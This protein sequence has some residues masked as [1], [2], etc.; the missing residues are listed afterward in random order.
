MKSAE[1]LAGL[2][3]AAAF[4]AGTA[5][6]A[7]PKPSW[8]TGEA[9][10]ASDLNGNFQNLENR[11]ATL[12]AHP[13]REFVFLKD[14]RSTGT[15]GGQAAGSTWVQRSLNTLEN[16]SAYSWVTLNG[17]QFTL[18]PGTYEILAFVPSHWVNRAQA[19]LRNLTDATTTLL[20]SSGLLSEREGVD[21]QA[22]IT[23]AN[24]L[25]GAFKVTGA[26]KTFQIE[27]IVQIPSAEDW[28]LGHASAFGVQ[29]VYTQVRL[30]RTGP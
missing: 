8:Q 14:V 25:M 6:S 10:T 26:T 16:P 28:T 27:S 2:L 24:T 22:S 21:G 20:S 9:L 15:N 29:E 30:A 12:E 5:V 17:N 7:L 1:R 4:L 3:V 13:T 19:R 18:S 11:V 23:A